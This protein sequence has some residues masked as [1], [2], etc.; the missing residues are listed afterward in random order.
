M[1]H[2][3]TL[4]CLSVFLLLQFVLANRPALGQEE[5]ESN[6]VSAE[7]LYPFP[8][9]YT[10]RQQ[11]SPFVS[12]AAQ[13]PFPPGSTPGHQLS[14]PPSVFKQ[15]HSFMGQFLRDVW[16]DQK[17]IYTS[18]F[19]I[20]RKQL[21]TIVL[22]TAAATAG[23]IATDERS[24]K[25]LA[26]TPGQIKWSQRVSDFGAVYT[27][28]VVTGGPLLGGKITHKPDYSRIGRLSLEA[29]VNS[30]VT[31][32]AIKG[33]TRRERPNAGDGKGR[34]FV[35]GQSFPSGHTM[36][37]WAVAVAVARSPNCPKW[38]AYTSYA[39]ATIVSLSRL[40]A[41]QH[42]PSDVVAG[43]VLGGLIGNYVAQRPR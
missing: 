11:L 19:R 36:N 32:Y 16:T 5:P 3:M 8:T 6:P 14:P 9:A 40:G 35:G 26:N 22:P 23:L 41:H 12:A 42:F 13:Q 43:G 29:L 21:L 25:Y 2:V 30:I 17:A 28:G 34:F 27:L 18:P 7:K 24:E 10:E 4:R 33:I 20:S 15:Q 1:R 39:M 31:N 37:S 38:F